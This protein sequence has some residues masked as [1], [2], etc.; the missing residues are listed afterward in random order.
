MDD[1]SDILM[2][3]YQDGWMVFQVTIDSRLSLRSASVK[4]PCEFKSHY[5]SRTTTACKT[6]PDI[7]SWGKAT[8]C[9]TYPDIV[10]WGKAVL[11]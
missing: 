4:T 5:C 7:V 3:Q 2:I 11:Y 9:K 6:Y 10:S 8:A 1:I